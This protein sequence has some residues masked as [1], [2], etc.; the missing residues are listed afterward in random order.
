MELLLFY[1]TFHRQWL[2]EYP[3][4]RFIDYLCFLKS[5]FFLTKC[6][7]LQMNIAFLIIAIYKML[8]LKS[9]E[10]KNVSE[11]IQLVPCAFLPLC[12]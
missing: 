9:M 3:N 11:K 1:T 12:L 5:S 2:V 8:K 6:F 7:F 4:W 10:R